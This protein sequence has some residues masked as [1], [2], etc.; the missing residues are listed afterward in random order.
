MAADWLVG[1][2]NTGSGQALEPWSHVSPVGGHPG[3][4]YGQTGAVIQP[5][6]AATLTIAA[7]ML[8]AM[9]GL[10]LR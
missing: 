10:D 2:I 7:T 1:I 3:A 6:M 4:L 5:I 8:N 9:S